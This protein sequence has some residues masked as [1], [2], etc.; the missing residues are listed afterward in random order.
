MIN[1]NLFLIFFAFPL[2]WFSYLL[3][4]FYQTI[5]ISFI[6]CKIVN[7]DIALTK[8]CIKNV[9]AVPSI[10]YKISSFLMSV[11][12]LDSEFLSDN[13]EWECSKGLLIANFPWSRLLK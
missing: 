1:A 2:G 13:G 9:C 6:Y 10:L 8:N 4:A 5:R 7:L 11:T 3:I 12:L